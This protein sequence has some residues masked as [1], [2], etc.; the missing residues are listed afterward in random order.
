MAHPIAE[1]WHRCALRLMPDEVQYLCIEN[2]RGDGLAKLG[3]GS[4]ESHSC[5][6][7]LPGRVAQENVSAVLSRL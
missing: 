7:V 5:K 2:T 1:L 4:N 6:E 3:G